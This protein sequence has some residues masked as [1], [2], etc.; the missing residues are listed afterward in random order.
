MSTGD[1]RGACELS[2]QESPAVDALL[3]ADEGQMLTVTADGEDYRA[4]LTNR[5]YTPAQH[6]EHGHTI[7]GWLAVDL[8]LHPETVRDHLLSS[9][10][11]ILRVDEVAPGEWRLPGLITHHPAT[12]PAEVAVADDWYHLGILDDVELLRQDPRTDGGQQLPAETHLDDDGLWIPPAFRGEAQL[13]IRTP[14]ATIQH[15]GGF[16]RAYYGMVD[17]SHFGDPD[18]MRDPRNPNLAPDS[19]HLK[20]VGGPAAELTVDRHS[21]DGDES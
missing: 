8:R 7:R 12:N 5:T 20:L 14:R 1:R 21:E 18:A 3:E 4:T 13:I 6:T 17:K 16:D 10:W 2:G 15:Y 19:V 9:H 11:A